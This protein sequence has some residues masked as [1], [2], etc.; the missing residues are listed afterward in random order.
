MAR[1]VQGRIDISYCQVRRRS[2]HLMEGE[3]IFSSLMCRRLLGLISS[4]LILLLAAC[5][6]TPSGQGEA[7]TATV[8]PTTIV[9]PTA[10]PSGPALSSALVT[11]R[12]HAGVVVMAAWSPDGKRIV[13]C[14][15]DATVQVWDAM[16]GHQ[17]WTYTFPNP[18]T[19]YTFAVAWSPDGKSIAAGGNTGMVAMLDAATGHLLATY[20]SQSTFIEGIAWSPD[21]KHV[22]FGNGDHTVE[23]WDATVGKLLVTYKGHSAEV[24][25]IAWSP[26][27]TR[28]ASASYDGTVQVWN[29]ATGQHLLTYKGQ[30]APVWSVAW[31]PDGKRIVSGTGGAGLDGPVMANNSAKVWDAATGQTLLSYMEQGSKN[32]VY[33]LAWSPDG[34]EIA[35]GGDDMLVRIWDATTGHTVLICQGHTDTIFSVAWSPDGKE[36]ASASV[37]NTVR[38]WRLK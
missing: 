31:S 32:Q 4:C 24:Q 1:L 35:S 36:I 23:V 10:A 16:T 19:S 28:I 5:G 11:Y 17:F 9:S 13:S 27:G 12:G 20:E 3:V 34:K 22:A 14:G 18:R 33:G 38:V 29:A 2:L 26:D 15:N 21:S 37:D 7:A 8:P 25:R 30:G 6:S